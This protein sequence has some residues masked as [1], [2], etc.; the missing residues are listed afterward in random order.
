MSVTGPM[1]MHLSKPLTFFVYRSRKLCGPNAVDDLVARSARNNRAAGVTGLLVHDP[2]HFL[3]FLEGPMEAVGAAV[4]RIAASDLHTDM[5][6]LAC[7]PT[8]MR[9]FSDWNLRAVALDGRGSAI[10]DL[11][12]SLDISDP[13]GCILRLRSYALQV[14]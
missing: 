5:T 10:A 6:I 4:L 1:P 8:D 9:L 13:Q 2:V 14:A 7:E 12:D 3:Q 11:A